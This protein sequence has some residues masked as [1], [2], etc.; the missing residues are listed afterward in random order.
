MTIPQG[1]QGPT[2]GKNSAAPTGFTHNGPGA[3]L[4]AISSTI[5][6]SVASDDVWAHVARTLAAPGPGR[7]AWSIER[8]RISITDAVPAGRAPTVLGYTISDYTPQRAVVTIV[9]REPDQSLSAT[10]TTVVWTAP[11]DWKRELPDI[12]T[13]TENAVSVLDE[14]PPHMISLP[15]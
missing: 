11:G 1:E 13:A 5:R 6:M 7:D 4:A 14:L 3:A 12:N 8:A 15:S 2:V 10:T 9:T